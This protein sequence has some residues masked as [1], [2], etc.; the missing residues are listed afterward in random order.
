[1]DILVS[2]SLAYDR[3]MDFPGRFSDHIMPD[4][5]HML[6]V[7]FTVS[8]PTEKFGGT[9][10]NIAY[11]LTLL[12]EA[13]RILAT[14]GHDYQPYHQWLN[15]H[16]LK[17]EDIRIIP[18]EPTACAYITTD[19]ADNQITGFSPGAMKQPSRFDF[20][21]VDPEECIAI[22]APG[23][24]EDMATYTRMCRAL[25]IFAI[26]DPGQSLPSWKGDELE[27]C[28]FES[29]MLIS[30]DYELA[31]I[32][33]KTGLSMSELLDKLDTVITTKGDH[34]CEVASRRSV[35]SIPAVSTKNVLDPTGAGDAFR[36]GL[37]KGL[38]E[39]KTVEQAAMMGAV[40]AH[41]AVQ[42]YGTQEYTF[43]RE[44]FN[45]VLERHFGV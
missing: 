45:A 22:V 36:G 28:I 41:Y 39:R 25:D 18:E 35:Q 26:F 44:E 21:K 3:I 20:E 29:R 38:A 40:C 23:N 4:K 5:I 10:G 43:T 33:D 8:T 32:R 2:G 31:L 7:S 42:S 27:R 1:M 34:G 9:A 16:G 12:G 17:T 13:P 15:D 30:N 14:L 37:I 19:L 24:L 11:A 6:N